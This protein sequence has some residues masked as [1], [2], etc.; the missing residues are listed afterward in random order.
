MNFEIFIFGIIV[1]L[2][3]IPFITF[4]MKPMYQTIGLANNTK[5]IFA[6]CAYILMIL[7]WILV[8]RDL[9][10]AALTGFIIY[11][12]YAFTLA[13]ILPTYTLSMALTEIIWGTALFTFATYLIIKLSI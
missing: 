8:E 3:D 1:L 6:L 12:I 5:I 4:I 10:K 7:A 2:L 9:F 13:A 11:G